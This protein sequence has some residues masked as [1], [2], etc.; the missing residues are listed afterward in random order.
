MEINSVGKEGWLE[1]SKK[2][3]LH[4]VSHDLLVFTVSLLGKEEYNINTSV[5]LMDS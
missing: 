5:G 4:R 1:R 2:S 3:K